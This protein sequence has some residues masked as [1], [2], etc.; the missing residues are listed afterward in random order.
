M[1]IGGK[2]SDKIEIREIDN[3]CVIILNLLK[4]EKKISTEM[5]KFEEKSKKW[6][7]SGDKNDNVEIDL[8]FYFKSNVNESKCDFC[9]TKKSNYLFIIL[10]D[11]IC[12]IQLLN[13]FGVKYTGK[14]AKIDN[15]EKLEVLP[16]SNSDNVILL[17]NNKQLFH[18]IY[19]ETDCSVEYDRTLLTN[20]V[21]IIAE[22]DVLLIVDQIDNE[23]EITVY[24]FENKKDLINKMNFIYKI[25]E[26][27]KFINISPDGKY[28]AIF[29]EK[30]KALNLYRL[31]N[32]D[33]K[34]IAQV[35]ILTLVYCINI[36]N[37]Y[38]TI[39]IDDNR[40]LSYLIVD[41]SNPNHSCRTK[42]LEEK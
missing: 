3:N 28:L 17:V 38:L 13:P 40:I 5:F 29:N 41:P 4:N 36:N 26:N 37:T 39:G 34:P 19:S 10:N 9:I 7:K 6:L 42:D 2:N 20:C 22:G 15:I 32:G 24:K 12:Y 11:Q 16:I 30:L 25:K 1:E 27:V 8:N 21:K 31:K 23:E 14:I 33:T 35:P 18:F